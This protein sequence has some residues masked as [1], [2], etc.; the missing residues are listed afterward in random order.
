MSAVSRPPAVMYDW[1]ILLVRR[2]MLQITVTVTPYTSILLVATIACLE[3]LNMTS[4]VALKVELLNA[5]FRPLLVHRQG[6][7]EEVVNSKERCAR[8]QRPK[9][10][11]N[12]RSYNVGKTQCQIQNDEGYCMPTI[13]EYEPV[14]ETGDHWP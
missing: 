9:C 8:Y 11:P 14:P 4:V 3:F 10:P 13:R 6:L 1:P 12:S 7:V 2:S 5:F